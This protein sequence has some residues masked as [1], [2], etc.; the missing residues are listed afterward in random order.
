MIITRFTSKVLFVTVIPVIFTA[1]F[2]ATILISGRIDEFNKRIDERGDNIANYLSPISEYGIFSNNFS[3]LNSTLDNSLTQPDI[4]AIYITDPTNNI[5]LKK[6]RDAWKEINI[7]NI[8]HKMYRVFQ[9]DIFK[10]SLE[11]DDLE[12]NP[13]DIIDS[14]TKI[15][16]VTV[17]MS[18][19][20]SRV[21]KSRIIKDGIFITLISTIIT[22]LI[23]L[24]FSRSVTK[25]ITDIH[26]SVDTI[27]KGDLHHRIS[28]DYKG[29]LAE[30]AHDINDMTASLEIAQIKDKQRA[31]D[32][33]FIEKTKAQITLEAIGEGVIT[34]DIHGNVTYINPTAEKLTGFSFQMAM[35]KPLSEIF[36]TKEE[37]DEYL[38][39][40]PIMDCIKNSK[41]IHHESGYI[42][43]RDDGTEFTIRE[44]ATPLFDK[45]KN[46]IGAVL[47][48][49]DF[50][51]IK[52]M[53][54]VLTYQATH[55]D[56]T[57][58]LN[59][60][61]FESNMH[62]LL[63]T[64]QKD[65][66]HALCYIDLDQF[67]IINDTC[68][69][70]AGDSLL[71]IISHKINE[72]IRRNDL[73]ARLGGDEFGI[74]FFDC[75][76]EK[77]KLLAENIRKI[78]SD[79]KF[80]W[81]VHTFKVASSIGIVPILYKKS[82][83]DLMMTVDTACY[84]AKDK[85]RNRIHVYES[86]DKDVLQRKGELQWFQKI[87]DAI[88]NNNFTLYSQK[89]TSHGSAKSH[90]IYEILIRLNENGNLVTP[91]V[92]IEAAERY[93]LMPRIDMWVISNLFR[94][95]NNN[96]LS[97]NNF[98]S[99][100]LS[101]QSLTDDSFIDFINTELDNTTIPSEQIIFEITETA[102]I[103]NF[104]DAN[105]FITQLK[106]RGC[107]FSLDDFGSGM[108]SFQYLSNLDIDYI[109]IDGSF[110]KNIENNA[111]NCSVVKSISEIGH[112]LNLEIIAEFVENDEIL[113]NLDKTLIDY[114]QGYGIERPRP[115]SELIS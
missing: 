55:D 86:N 51:N 62:D 7:N 93:S 83:T 17:V 6:T 54:D 30:L 33:L 4:I 15:G 91:A 49:H 68:G 21:A 84:I 36:K 13:S 80:T 61:A 52:K 76:I 28:V 14:K 25:P 47:V 50:T 11:I 90:N 53:S 26:N 87:H 92:F 3:Y 42:L 69:H 99:I 89:I 38:S 63:R 109:K 34:T 74:I 111:F 37:N 81:D 106:H 96:K 48:F 46:V 43:Y 112:S 35:N 39:D 72:N 88:D 94:S 65:S 73:F 101:G 32:A 59:R 107:K 77:A 10:T 45:E 67:K 5:I 85:G 104:S 75:D 71:K 79:I 60:R 22:A 24:L 105:N 100:N 82:M 1:I 8:N 64:M 114:V 12:A 27:K 29:E 9:S 23:A 78:I 102:A 113:A 58:L 41:R 115:L 40:Y 44:T 2:L 57:G 110:I 66:S 97:N 18:L 95:I 98:F 70:L 103:S 16:V 56:L 108:S 19:T 31:E 20:N